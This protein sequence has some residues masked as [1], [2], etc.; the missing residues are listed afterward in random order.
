M[1]KSLFTDDRMSEGSA[2]QRFDDEII[3]DQMRNE[4][5]AFDYSKYGGVGN[6]DFV[7]DG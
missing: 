5:A 2:K 3:R 1:I 7:F 4:V 6:P